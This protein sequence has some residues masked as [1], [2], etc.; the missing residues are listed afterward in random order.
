M[1]QAELERV[2]TELSGL[3]GVWAAG[4]IVKGS[5]VALIGKRTGHDQWCRFG[6][7]NAM[8]G[9]VDGLI[10]GAGTLSHARGGELSDAE[11]TQQVER[12]R[13]L[14]LINA[15]ADVLY[16]AGGL[17][18]AARG[19]DGRTTFRMGRGDGLA[20]LVQGAFLLALDTTYARRLA[21]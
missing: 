1:D 21:P 9:V 14:L 4:S 20:I 12:L 19:R 15:A 18:I 6:R 2:K 3:L 10:A 5:I 13:R 11:V 8:W 16:V 7:Q 17:L